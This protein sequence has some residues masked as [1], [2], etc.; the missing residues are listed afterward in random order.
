MN[1]PA[2]ISVIVCTTGRIEHLRRCLS[3]LS[4]LDGSEPYDA[5]V[6]DNDPSHATR[7]IAAQYATRYVTEPV[8]GLSRARNAGV[9]ATASEIVAFIDD[10]ATADV[11]WL[12]SI[13]KEFDDPRVAAVAGQVFSTRTD[14]DCA[15]FSI[16]ER[17][18]IDRA[19]PHWFEIAAFGG[20]GNGPNI[21]FRRSALLQIG[22]FDPRLG[23]G[24]AIPGSDEHDVFLRLVNAGF[25]VVSSPLPIVVHTPAATDQKK[26]ASI[27]DRAGA[28][29]IL[30]SLF[31]RPALRRQ[32][33]G[34]LI[35]A[36]IRT[37]RPWRTSAQR[38]VRMSWSRRL[39][40]LLA[41]AVV[42]LRA[43]A[44]PD[45]AR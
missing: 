27:Q 25:A 9:R 15:A 18:V 14:G 23:L 40:A 42:A 35:G 13:A 32:F 4:A 8:R 10:D 11:A 31:A 36:A 6:V 19:D 16:S 28:A 22:G 39:K 2:R 37:P 1:P 45:D 5:I 34:Y 12:T 26:R 21:S 3:S 30:W 43:L 41:G 24:S 20:V 33:W 7:E 44:K 29:Y 17:R 38:S